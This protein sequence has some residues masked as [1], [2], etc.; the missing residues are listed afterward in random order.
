MYGEKGVRGDGGRVV[1]Y[2]DYEVEGSRGVGVV[3]K[4]V[5]EL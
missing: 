3:L 4:F 2:G 5:E 1:V